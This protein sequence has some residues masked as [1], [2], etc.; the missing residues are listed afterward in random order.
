M[1]N[2]LDVVLATNC[3]ALRPSGDECS[4]SGEDVEE[5]PKGVLAHFD[6]SLNELSK[7]LLGRIRDLE[8][9][10]MAREKELIRRLKQRDTL[11]A[12][13]ESRMENQG[14]CRRFEQELSD[15]PNTA[16][17]SGEL[18]TPPKG[19]SQSVISKPTPVEP[20]SNLAPAMVKCASSK[21]VAEDQF[22]S[23]QLKKTSPRCPS[24]VR[25]SFGLNGPTTLSTEQTVSDGSDESD[26]SDASDVSEVLRVRWRK[27]QEFRAC[28]MKVRVRFGKECLHWI[29]DCR[30]KSPKSFEEEALREYRCWMDTLKPKDKKLF[31]CKTCSKEVP[32]KRGDFRKVVCLS[33]F[34][35]KGMFSDPLVPDHIIWYC[36]QM[37]REVNGLLQ[38]EN[39][40]LKS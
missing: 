35:P 33:C 36:Q 5:K 29:N 11:I 26:A 18:S 7:T 39:F 2:S 6:K 25:K 14:Q 30:L 40:L 17:P 19:A 8:N 4:S 34:C 28:D 1:K 31:T 13:L 9:A 21:L 32:E 3:S 10:S 37:F 23:N 27:R 16:S 22:S 15:T 12:K 24:C 20:N 38:L